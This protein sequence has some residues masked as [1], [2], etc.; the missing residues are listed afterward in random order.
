MASSQPHSAILKWGILGT[1]RINRSIIPALNLSSRNKL[2]AIASRSKQRADAHALEWGISASYGSYE[3]LLA[4]PGIDVVYIPL[5]N[6]L[7]CEWVIK[8]AQAGKHVLC[9]KPLALSNEEVNEMTNASIK[10]GVVLTEAF[11]YRH[12][13]QTLKVK[14]LIEA[15]A[16]GEVLLVRG[17]FSFPLSRKMD[18]RLKPEL[19]G[20]SL[21]DIGCYPVSYARY[22][23]GS[24]PITVFGWRLLGKT[25]IDISFTGHME[26]PGNAFAQFDCSFIM[27]VRT[28]LEIVGREGI[29]YLPEPFKPNFNGT[30]V[31]VRD[32]E[33]TSIKVSGE[34]LYAG[35]I[36]DITDAILSGR[37]PRIS[38]ED[39]RA[40]IA[41]IQALYASATRGEP[42]ILLS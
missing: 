22:I 41:T 3:G 15:G 4:E 17:S 33:E 27:P 9:E 2:V 20:G 25:G 26:F 5:P 11:M 21:W 38:I 1:A 14:E 28:N 36:E 34:H 29:I 16:I 19:G 37:A 39:S 24:E 12:H 18:V 13:P 42:V 35:E 32:D 40:N 23:L 31:L 10:A 6:S 8:A 7:H 30:I